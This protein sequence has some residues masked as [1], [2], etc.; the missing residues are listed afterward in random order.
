[1]IVAATGHRPGKLGKWRSD[2]QYALNEFAVRSLGQIRPTGVISGMA[3]GWDQ[4]V[5]IACVRLGIP[6][7]AAI[8]FEGQESRWPKSAQREYRQII[9]SASAVHICSSGEDVLWSFR[10]RNQWMVDNAQGV[11]ALWDG[12]RSGGTFDMI[13]YAQEGL[14]EIKNFWAEWE[15]YWG[16]GRWLI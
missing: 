11:V 6:F 15:E 13:T 2:L 1:M 3:Q 8:P 7:V 9:Q 14:R 12:T 4:S 5:A 10:E 16:S